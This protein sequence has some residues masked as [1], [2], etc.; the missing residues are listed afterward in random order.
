VG[1]TLAA[2]WVLVFS[3]VDTAKELP[4]VPWVSIAAAATAVAGIAVAA[5]LTLDMMSAAG[6]VDSVARTRA[7]LGRNALKGQDATFVAR[8]R[9]RHSLLAILASY[10][11]MAPSVC[12]TP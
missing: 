7:S 5:L 12:A 3:V 9:A 4:S 8:P 1:L 10:G 11:D 6:R 2:G